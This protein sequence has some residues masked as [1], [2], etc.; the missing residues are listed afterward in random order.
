MAPAS[1]G[2]RTT[3]GG[4]MDHADP[5]GLLPEEMAARVAEWGWP[6]YRANQMFGALQRRRAASWEDAGGLPLAARRQLGAAMPFAWPAVVNRFAA[7]D[8]TVRYLLRLDD[9]E[10][11]EAVF[12]PDEVFDA[13][14][15]TVRRRT[16]FCLSTQ[17]GCPVNCQFCLTAKL[18]LKRN[19]T[20]GEIAGQVLRLMYEHRIAPGAGGERLNLVYM[21]MGEPF[22]NYAAVMQS[23]RILTHPHGVGLPARRITVSTSGIVDKIRR[24]GAE[25]N[26]PR[27]A[28][29]LNATT[30]EL[31]QRLM[32][33]HRAQGGLA[34]LTAAA[35][36]FPLG[37]RERLTW[38]YVLL[39]GINDRP[40][41]ADRL[42][43]LSRGLRAKVN[44]IAWNAGPDIEFAQPT[45]ETVLAFQRRL[46]AAGLP[47]YI[48]RP[49]GREVYAACGQLSFRTVQAGQ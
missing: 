6:R 8:G 47:A 9:G 45:P 30:D 14:G 19:L 37:P 21:G 13:E 20:A 15:R 17:A 29:S 39:A 49:R 12:L 22:L 10:T 16:T 35:R 11:V 27:L 5:L 4:S 26:R 36:A 2:E 25:P 31:R 3:A 33:L 34:A 44:L 23:V 38:E 48:R 42:T 28:I 41:D 32:P 46:T 7:A 43:A 40:A 18:G 1:N 24:F